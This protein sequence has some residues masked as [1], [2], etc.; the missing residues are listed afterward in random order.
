M[1]SEGAKHCDDDEDYPSDWEQ[2]EI[3]HGERRGQMAPV[4]AENLPNHIALG[5]VQTSINTF[6]PNDKADQRT[7]KILSFP[8]WIQ[9]KLVASFDLATS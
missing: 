9:V 3:K 7:G 1:E 8:N 4:A 6:A 5:S 2:V